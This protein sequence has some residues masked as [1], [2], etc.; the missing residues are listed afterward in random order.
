MR[1]GTKGVDVRL[2]RGLS[3]S[4]RVVRRDGKPVPDMPVMAVPVD[5]KPLYGT[6]AQED[7][8]DAAGRFEITGL[9]PGVIHVQVSLSDGTTMTRG[10]LFLN[11]GE[12]DVDLIVSVERQ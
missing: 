2:E 9:P 6:P 3:V 12:D 8:T 4:G 11:A 7:V 5:P 10:H 1:V